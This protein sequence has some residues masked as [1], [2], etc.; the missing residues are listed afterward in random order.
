MI[1]GLALRN[2]FGVII[3]DALVSFREIRRSGGRW[4]CVQCWLRRNSHVFMD[5]S[6]VGCF[7]FFNTVATRVV[8]LAENMGL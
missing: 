8:R 5:A 2:L 6:D 1:G 7:S 3:G 4:L